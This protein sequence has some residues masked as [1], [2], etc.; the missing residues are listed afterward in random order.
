MQGEKNM[1]ESIKSLISAHFDNVI[2]LVIALSLVCIASG[3][4]AAPVLGGSVGV[5]SD[6]IS[7]GQLQ[8]AGGLTL[9][10][11]VYAEW[12]GLYGSVWA[13]ELDY[14]NS[15][16]T[17]V[18]GPASH[19]IDTVIGFQKQWEHIG[20]NVAYIDF[21]YRGD[22][23]YDYEEILLSATVAGFTISHYMGQDEAGDYTEYSTGILKVVDLEY[24]DAEGEGTH[25]GISKTFDL[26]NGSM[27]VGW[28]DFTADDNSGFLDED[29]IF[30]GYT[31]E[32]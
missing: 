21:H 17:N 5:S 13:S 8:T 7:R 25:W 26:F 24:G 12:G 22:T 16:S 2:K 31:Y 19:E 4:N 18:D 15:D 23:S 10:A 3:V 27:Q 11:E 14:A 1:L 30:V 9:S 20:L 6:Y 29:N 32:F 28:T